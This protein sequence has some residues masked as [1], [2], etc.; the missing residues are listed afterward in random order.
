MATESALKSNPKWTG[1]TK[2]RAIKAC[3]QLG[4]AN[5]TLSG[6]S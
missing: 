3:Y 2:E 6:P 1:P 5:S 4:N